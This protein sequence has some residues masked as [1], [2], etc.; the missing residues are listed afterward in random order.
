MNR[1]SRFFTQHRR[2]CSFLGRLGVNRLVL[3]ASVLQVLD[4]DVLEAGVLQR[5]HVVQ[6]VRVGVG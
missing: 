5:H 3:I 2:R 4:G 1:V 6:R